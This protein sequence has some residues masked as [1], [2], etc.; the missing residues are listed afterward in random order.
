MTMAIPGDILCIFDDR[1]VCVGLT[2]TTTSGRIAA[3]D[4]RYGSVSTYE[5]QEE[6]VAAIFRRNAGERGEVAKA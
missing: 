2:W 5:T 6:A 4:D 1:M 3:W